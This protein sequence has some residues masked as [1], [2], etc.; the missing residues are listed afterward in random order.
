MTLEELDK[1]LASLASDLEAI[2][3]RT[4]TL[5]T[6]VTYRT[7]Q[8]SQLTGITETQVKEA[9]ANVALIWSYRSKLK[10][11]HDAATAKRA[12]MPSVFRGSA[13]DEI[14]QLLDG[15]SILI[16]RHS[17]TT[18]SDIFAGDREHRVSATKIKEAIAAAFK[19][20]DELMTKLRTR[21][22]EL[23]DKVAGYESRLAKMKQSVTEMGK[24]TPA[25]LSDLEARVKTQRKKK[26]QDPLSTTAA[27]VDRQ[28]ES[29]ATKALVKV[30]LLE[31]ELELV[32]NDVKAAHQRLEDLKIL[33]GTAL[34]F[35]NRC[36]REIRNQDLVTVPPKAKPLGDALSLLDTAVKERRFVDAANGLLSWTRD[37]IAFERQLNLSITANRVLLERRT[38]LLTRWTAIKQKAEANAHMELA[39][40]RALAKFAEKV[41]E[42]TTDTVDVVEAEKFVYSYETRVG[43]LMAAF[44]NRPVPTRSELL[45]AKFDA[46]QKQ[47]REKGLDGNKAMIAFTAKAEEAFTADDLDGA[48][49]WIN[50]YTTKLGE[51]EARVLTSPPASE[52]TTT[53]TPP[54]STTAVPVHPS[55]KDTLQT[56]LNASIRQAAEAGFSERKSLNAFAARAAEAIAADDFDT[57]EAMINSHEV[58]LQELLAAG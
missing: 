42:L 34:D 36:G 26:T 58:K 1:K 41:V 38:Q 21:W 17:A 46:A 8:V 18:S 53:D 31:R 6:S 49:Q 54:S 11:L 23:E 22:L 12:K 39:D 20:A 7:A 2:R 35:S 5:E 57:A 56:R 3:K 55:R 48:E 16:E 50:A 51:L 27:E 14:K 44:A 32:G 19:S 9:F 29:Y 45:R 15:D 43:E 24:P 33:R 47:A 37:A 40:D 52:P 4:E 28:L 30:Q 10:D 25:E 13:I